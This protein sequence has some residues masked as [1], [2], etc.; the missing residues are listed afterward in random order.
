[1]KDSDK[2]KVI[3]IARLLHEMGYG[4]IATHGTADAV[5]ASGIPIRPINKVK[6]GRPHVVDALKNGEIDLVI[7]TVSESR[8]QIADSRSIRT[9]AIAQRVN[10]YTTVAGG[11]AAVE[12]MKHLAQLRVYDLQGLH[13]TLAA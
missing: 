12:G 10:Y 7:T 1:V 6:D 2:P 5:A 11:R 3:E 9:T 13:R 4:L 8:A